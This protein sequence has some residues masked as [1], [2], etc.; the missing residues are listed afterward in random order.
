M[1]TSF[2]YTQVLF[3]RERNRFVEHCALSFLHDYEQLNY[4]P[5]NIGIVSKGLQISM[6][7][8][9]IRGICR[10]SSIIAFRN[11]QRSN[12]NTTQIVEKYIR[13]MSYATCTT[14]T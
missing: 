13:Q 7:K 6:K 2:I 3:V 9:S 5:D 11:R 8:E 1:H 10:N 4:I 14:V 12:L